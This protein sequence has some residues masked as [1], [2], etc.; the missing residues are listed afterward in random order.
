MAKLFFA[1]PVKEL[2]PELIAW[3]DQQPW[4]GQPVPQANLHL[5]L[6]F[7]GEADELTTRRLIA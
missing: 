7:L 6:A 4:P 1:L 2:A 5:T 3:R